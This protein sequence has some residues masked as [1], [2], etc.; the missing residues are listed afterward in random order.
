MRPIAAVALGTMALLAQGCPSAYQRTY[1]RE[2]QKLEAE[3]RAADAQERAA[4]AEASRYAAVVYFDVGSAVIGPEVYLKALSMARNVA[5]QE[6]RELR[7]FTTA[8]FDLVS[9]GDD[10]SRE[11]AKTDPRY[12][13]RP[14]KTIL[15]RTVADGG[16]SF[17]VQGDHRETLPA[18]HR[19]A[20][21]RM[22]SPPPMPR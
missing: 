16:E 2:T 5:R 10:L 15:A 20:I 19:A 17:Y 1:E 7:H 14:W 13:Y 22:T 12:Y 11:A 9:L 6:G 18:L 4:Q 8:V 3:Q 21:G